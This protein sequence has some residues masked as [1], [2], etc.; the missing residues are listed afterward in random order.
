MALVT[1]VATTPLTSVLYPPWYQKKLDAWKRGEIDW[2]GNPLAQDDD[3]EVSEKAQSTRVQNVLIYLRLDS[4]PSLFTFINLLGEGNSTVVSRV[5]PSKS[6]LTSAPEHDSTILTTTHSQKSRPL[7]VHGVR[8]MELTER[9]S[10]VM[11]ITEEHSVRD[12]VVNAFQTFAQLNN[13]ASSGGLSVVPEASYAET[14]ASKANHLTSDLILIPWSENGSLSDGDQDV[15]SV[16]SSEERFGGTSHNLFI[17]NALNNAVRNTAIFINRGFGGITHEPCA[18]ARRQSNL[19]MHGLGTSLTMS[20]VLDRS[21]HIFLP[22][23]GG[24]D[25]QVALRFVLQLAKSSNVTATILHIVTAMPHDL[26]KMPEVA[27]LA[28]NSTSERNA[29]PAPQIIEDRS[30]AQDTAFIHSLRDSLPADLERR[31][32]FEET[33]ASDVLDTVLAAAAKEVGQ[34]RGNAG[35]LIV[36]GRNGLDSADSSSADAG[37]VLGALAEGVL[38]R[39][40]WASVLVMKAGTQL[41]A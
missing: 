29:F 38:R 28:I 30:A 2:E 35:D 34:A 39:K 15:V 5:H 32:V 14:L 27:M 20:P 12:P 41:V 19:N 23:F 31:V 18:I 22:F 16:S 13:V 10:S 25:D 3:V 21:H 9:T 1:T 26:P 17:S 33:I 24:A 11:K 40:L 7:Q 8:L 6:N 37:R 36:L 4:L